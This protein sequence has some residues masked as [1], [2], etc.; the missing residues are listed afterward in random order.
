MAAAQNWSGRRDWALH[1]LN[2]ARR[3][4]PESRDA[5]NLDRSVRTSL[6]PLGGAFYDWNEDSDDYRVNSFWG[7]VA[8]FPHPQLQLVPFANVVGIRRPASVDID[9]TWVG[10]TAA[11][12]PLTRLGLWGRLSWLTDPGEGSE[13]SPVAGALRADW[14]AH[15][16]VRFGGGF[17]RFAVVSFRTVPDKI[18]G[19]S[20]GVFFEG[21]PDW[22]S[23]VRV[24]TDFARYHPVAGFEANHR[25][26]LKAAAS[27]QV[28]APARLRAG[29]TVRYL[30]FDNSPDNGIWTPDRFWAVAG[31]LEW[32]VGVRD[33]WSLNGSV[34]IGPA[35]ETGFDTSVF[36]AWR[37]GFFRALGGG[38][39]FD[40]TVGHSE[41]N[42]DTWTGY[43][44]TY[45][46]IGLRRRF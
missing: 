7:E 20:Y 22:L 35:R 44:R 46:T 3:L 2:E 4:D 6:R 15:D 13:Y 30:D 40:V 17:E 32:D 28:W 10:L 25:W 14:T 43:D 5:G 16:R 29:A 11:S 27:R 9:E 38:L 18:T 23:R 36:A 34:E 12:R 37:V 21:R 41:G 33:A 19:E 39:L 31:L 42:V 26:N 8:F 1:S 45:A 24:D